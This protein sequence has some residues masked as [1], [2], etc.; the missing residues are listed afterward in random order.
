MSTLSCIL[1]V[2]AN[3]SIF[4]LFGGNSSII[5]IS[6]SPYKINAR[7]L[8]IGVAD[9]T[10]TSGFCP[11]LPFLAILF[12]CLTP[13]LCCSSVTTSPKFLNSTLSSSNACVPIKIS[14]SPS[15]KFFK[16]SSF[17]FLVI[18]DI[19]NAD[20]IPNSVN[21]LSKFSK[22]CVAK[23][24]VGAII[25]TW[26]PDF[27]AL[28]AAIIATIVDPTSPCNNLFIIF[29][30]SISFS[31]SLN[32]LNC[33]F[34]NWNGNLFTKSSILYSDENFIPFS[35]NTS[36]FFNDISD[37]CVISN[38]SNT[39]LFLAILKSFNSCG[40]CIV[41]IASFIP[42]ILFVFIIYCGNVS[43]KFPYTSFIAFSII[44]LKVFCESWY[45]NGYIG[46]ILPVFCVLPYSSN[47]GDAIIIFP[48]FFSIFPYILYFFPTVNLLF[49][50]VWLNHIAS[51]ELV[52]SLI[53]IFCIV[54]LENLLSIIL[55]IAITSIN[56]S[57]PSIHSS[58][59]FGLLLSS[60]VLG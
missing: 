9:I 31:I 54:F 52:L 1:L 4:F 14:I 47:T 39:N 43:G 60:Y 58:K 49:R 27:T 48:Y 34:V 50:Y 40:K 20:F 16:I 6:R 56:A 3:V 8:G 25:A 36:L 19:S 13:N 57:S 12:L 23:I 35:S 42:K 15:F 44:F 26:Y 45:V 46:I 41:F 51:A 37:N 21:I 59:L 10:N 33:A 38:S 5:D 7:V 24:A 53:I 29:S 22:C 28:Y 2:T 17:F 55:L 11:L 32:T 30:D 18:P